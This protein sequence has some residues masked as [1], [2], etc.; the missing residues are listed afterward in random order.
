MKSALIKLM[1]LLS[2]FLGLLGAPVPTSLLAT[3]PALPEA[4]FTVE[5]VL[6]VVTSTAE[7]RIVLGNNSSE[8]CLGED[9]WRESRLDLLLWRGCTME[10]KLGVAPAVELVMATESRQLPTVKVVAEATPQIAAQY[11][12]H[13]PSEQ[14]AAILPLDLYRTLTN[15]NESTQLTRSIEPI[16]TGDIQKT[17]SIN[18]QQTLTLRC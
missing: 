13:T 10:L 14:S 15:R 16:E 1:V 18:F 3:A 7:S 8:A 17:F 5:P 6:P 12:T 4:V 2:M 11:F 9:S